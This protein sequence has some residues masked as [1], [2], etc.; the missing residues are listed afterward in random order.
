MGVTRVQWFKVR[1]PSNNRSLRQAQQRAGRCLHVRTLMFVRKAGR[2]LEM[3]DLQGRERAL[4][5]LRLRINPLPARSDGL[6][7]IDSGPDAAFYIELAVI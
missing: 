5:R 4:L 7:N 1:E 6:D 2:S 3:I